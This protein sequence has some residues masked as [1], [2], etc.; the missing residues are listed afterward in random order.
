ATYRALR[1]RSQ[2]GHA[3]A[4]ADRVPEHA[5]RRLE[6]VRV[7]RYER[8]ALAG[9]LAGREIRVAD[10]SIAGGDDLGA[11]L[12]EHGN[13][14]REAEEDVRI[15]RFVEEVVLDEDAG[16]VAGGDAIGVVRKGRA[17]VRVVVVEDVHV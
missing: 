17:A 5:V 1:H 11:R 16:L 10:V 3:R 13:T 9:E 2:R 4:M 12:G 8:R 15:V 14:V 6:R 7:R